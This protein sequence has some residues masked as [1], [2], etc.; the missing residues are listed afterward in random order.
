MIRYRA[1]GRDNVGSKLS[2][3]S[4][5]IEKQDVSCSLTPGSDGICRRPSP[6]NGDQSP[7]DLT[8]RTGLADATSVS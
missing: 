3:C 5:R 1:K 4:P 2:T 7:Q 8:G 6:Q